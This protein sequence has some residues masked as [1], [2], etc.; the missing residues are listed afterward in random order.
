MI[1]LKRKRLIFWLLRAYL[2]KWGKTIG[3]FFIFG[4]SIIFLLFFNRNLLFSKIPV[5]NSQRVGVAGIYSSRDVPSNL[6]EIILSKSSRG[7]TKISEKGEVTA[8]IAKSWEIKD[9]G[10]TFVFYLKEGIRFS[11]GEELDSSAINYNFEDA[12]IERPAKQVIIFKLRHKYSPFLVTLANHRI[13]KENY[14]GISD[15]KIKK[16]KKNDEFIRSIELVNA[17]DKQKIEYIF[18]DTQEALKHAYV[19]GEITSIIDINDLNYKNKISFEN[20]NNTTTSKNINYNK[21]VTIFFNNSDPVLSDKKI[22]KALAY[23]LPDTFPD[24]QRTRTPYVNEYWFS[25]KSQDYER[26][27]EYA[28]LLLEQTEASKSAT[29]KIEVKALPQY[30][31]LAESV[32]KE[33]EKIGI[34]TKIE[35]VYGVPSS[36]QV[37]LGEL[38]VLRDPD[39]YTLWHTG[40]DSNITNYRNLRIDKLL[41]DGRR[42][43][44]TSERRKIYSDFQKYLLDDMPAAFLFFPYTYTISRK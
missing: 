30:K 40:Q 41:E 44:N 5:V 14:V 2:K 8:D 36:Y 21:I 1:F 32:S 7:L 43:Y 34:K 28:R 26:D 4:F 12:T 18:Y 24:G 29:I 42:T 13:F 9:D 20:F 27:I 6:P 22:R 11:D 10:K 15:Y 3:A 16:I 17:L 33:W 25:D 37:F 23:S 31:T 38:P 39:Q 35:V 19:L